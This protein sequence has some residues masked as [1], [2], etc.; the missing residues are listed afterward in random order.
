VEHPAVFRDE[1]EVGLVVRDDTRRSGAHVLE[2]LADVES[3]GAR[4]QQVVER[5]EPIHLGIMMRIYSS[6]F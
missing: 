4:R 6:R 5:V 3:A 1:D 2:N